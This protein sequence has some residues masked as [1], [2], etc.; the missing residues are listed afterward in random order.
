MLQA[1][2][3]GGG[4]ILA[5]TA[6]SDLGQTF[7][8][9]PWSPRV[10]LKANIASG[11]R[12]PLDGDLET[13]NAL[14]PRGAYFAESGL[15]GPANFIDVH[16]SLTL[17]PAPTIAVTADVD[18]FWRQSTRDG[19]YGPAVNLVRTGRTSE[20]R[21]IGT[22]ASLQVAGA[23]AVIGRSRRPTVVSSPGNFCANPAR[24]RTS[25]M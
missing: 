19:L 10:G 21:Y 23:P 18:F 6:A 13:F 3:F 2:E 9:L 5:W 12:D 4:D 7:A 15:I 17:N 16:P 8:A 11:D 20:A 24:A 1:G 22:Q 14:F 25:I